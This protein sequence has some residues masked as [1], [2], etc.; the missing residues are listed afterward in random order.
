M[1]G[2]YNVNHFAQIPSANIP[3][4]RFAM[5]HSLKTTVESGELVPIFVQEVLPGDTHSID[6]TTF[7]RLATPIT[8]FMDDIIQEVFFFFVPN[9]LIWDNWEKFCG[10][11]KNPGDSIDYLVPQVRTTDAEGNNLAKVGTLWD[12]F[13]LP[14]VGSTSELTPTSVLYADALAFRAYNLIYNEWFRDENLQESVEVPLGDDVSDLSLFPIRRR[15]KRHDYF[16]ASL[17]WPQKGPGVELPLGTVAPLSLYNTTGTSA[18]SDGLGS[19]FMDYINGTYQASNLIYA[20]GFQEGATTGATENFSM[21]GAW[22]N[23]KVLGVD[24]TDVTAVTINSLREAFQIQGLL[25]R[26]AVG[27]TR[28]TEILRAHFGC[29]SPD[30]RLQRPEFLGGFSQPVIVNP[31]VQNSSTNDTTPQ[32]NLAGYGVVGSSR[33]GFTKSFVEHGII[34]GLVNFRADLSYQQGINRMWSRRSRYDFFWPALAHL[35]E[36]AVLNKEIYAQGSSANSPDDFYNEETDNNDVFGYQERYAEYRYKPSLITGKMRSY[37]GESDWT[38]EQ[39]KF[40]SLDYWHLAQNFENLPRL[41]SEFIEENPPLDRVIAVPSE[42]QF[43]LDCHFNL[44]SVR[45]I[46]VYATPALLSRF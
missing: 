35:G 20:R 24:L 27:G 34:I 2:N 19:K 44:V 5:P 28:Y 32:G 41:N 39:G 36:Q 29:I 4:S 23:T 21:A 31:V 10:E 46:P 30:A 22:G 33:H 1:Q 11:R 26:D 40:E 37:N 17:P 6:C 9:R 25:E 38:A 3:R 42:P 18:S 12:Y 14:V 43:L 7:G 8:P 15:G 45:P 13:G 16:S